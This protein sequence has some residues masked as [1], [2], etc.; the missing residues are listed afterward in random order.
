MDVTEVPQPSGVNL[1]EPYK[2]AQLLIV[3]D[4]EV[5]TRL[6]RHML[7]EAGFQHIFELHEP[8]ESFTTITQLKP[9]LIF[10]DLV[11]PGIDGLSILRTLQM[12]SS[13]FDPLPVIVL[14]AQEGH[15]V[16]KSALEAGASDFLR[17]PVDQYELILRANNLL[18]TRFLN[19]T[20]QEQNRTLEVLIR[21]N[22]Q[23]LSKA[24]SMVSQ[25]HEESLWMMGLALEYRDYET[26]GHTN[27][28]AKLSLNL[29]KAL[30]LDQT[31]LN[32][33]RWG[34]YLH[35]IGKIAIS[36]DILLKPGS[37]SQDEFDHM[38]KHVNYGEDLLKHISFLPQ[39]VLK[40]VRHHHERWD[41]N[42]YPDGL[43]GEDIP[44]LARIFS[45][46]DVYDALISE[47]PYKLAWEEV[48]AKEEIVLQSEHQFDPYIVDAFLGVVEYGDIWQTQF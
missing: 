41:G 2:H 8:R 3:D 33:L 1:A 13:P 23:D 12:Q 28:V 5:N 40:L 18:H 21:E 15:D 17:K 26:K 24:L 10:L 22:S 39:E 9:D 29:G 35:D 7:S 47:R 42:G 6:L 25:S 31:L 38:K 32:H 4:D 34:A 30:G 44:L 45:V 27:R 48:K 19:R 37:L 46:V 36:D 43:A 20:L 11:M 14:T 16:V